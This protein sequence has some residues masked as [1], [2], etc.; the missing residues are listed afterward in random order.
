MKTPKWTPPVGY[1]QAVAAVARRHLTKGATARRPVAEI[2]D[3]TGAPPA[4]T[5]EEKVARALMVAEAMGGWALRLLPGA[6]MMPV[7]EVRRHL[8]ALARGGARVGG[9]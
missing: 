3:L 6:L 4:R 5:D 2:F 8:V 7:T 1:E 9:A